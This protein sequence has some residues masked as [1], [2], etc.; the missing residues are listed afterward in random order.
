MAPNTH[1]G[2]HRLLCCFDDVRPSCTE[3]QSKNQIM[4]SHECGCL[5][6]TECKGRRVMEM[7]CDMHAQV[8]AQ[9]QAGF[10]LKG[11]QCI[12]SLQGNSCR[13]EYSVAEDTDRAS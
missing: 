12:S 10:L 2:R 5:C 4:S 13:Q 9:G 3:L 11:M 7:E 1:S 6:D 8:L